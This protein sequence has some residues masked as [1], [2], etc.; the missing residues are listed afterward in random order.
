[1]P[2]RSPINSLLGP[3]ELNRSFLGLE[4]RLDEFGPSAEIG[5]PANLVGVVVVGAF[6]NIEEFGRY[7]RL[8]D[9]PAEFERDNVVFVAV[10]DQ[11]RER[12]LRKAIDQC[13]VCPEQPMD[14]HPP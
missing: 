4:D 7:R 12:E 5:G 3:V 10:N 8:E 14:R 2:R 9:L 6:D 13:E 11:L 1:M